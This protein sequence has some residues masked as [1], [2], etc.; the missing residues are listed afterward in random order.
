MSK[1]EP[2]LPL[3]WPNCGARLI[4]EDATPE[5]QAYR[6]PTCRRRFLLSA[7]NLE[8]AYELPRAR[9][10]YV[11]GD[12]PPVDQHGQPAGTYTPTPSLR[13]KM[14]KPGDVDG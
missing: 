5:A 7:G 1:D 6:C 4:D 11:P 14:D 9:G 13:L 2:P 8:L 3:N 10:L 12:G